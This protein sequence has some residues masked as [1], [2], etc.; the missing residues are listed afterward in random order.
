ML[1]IITVLKTS[2]P[3]DLRRPNDFYSLFVPDPC[4]LSVRNALTWNAYSTYM[5]LLT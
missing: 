4:H 3:T 5:L 1:N 2:V